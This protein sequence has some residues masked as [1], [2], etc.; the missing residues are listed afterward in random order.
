MSQ[1]RRRYVRLSTD[2]NVQCSIPGVDVVHIVG[3]GE[4]GTG[5][6]I[7]TNRELPEGDFPVEL[8]LSDGEEPLK[9]MGRV[10]WQESW[11]FEI[12]NRVVAG[13]SLQGMDESA[14]R[15]F[16]QVM[17]NSAGTADGDEQNL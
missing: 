8:D 13:V 4:E 12:F 10:A 5:M 17:A 15:R 2:H 3:L 6:R 9:L 11:D 1:E 14:R 7:I 16:Q